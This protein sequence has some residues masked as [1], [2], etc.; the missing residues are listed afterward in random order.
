MAIR[1]IKAKVNY[2]HFYLN[3]ILIRTISRR[4]CV[5]GQV[6]LTQ[7]ELDLMGEGWGTLAVFETEGEAVIFMDN[8]AHSWEKLDVLHG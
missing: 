3:L 6:S 7:K 1:S 4:Y 2:K 8:L 5:K